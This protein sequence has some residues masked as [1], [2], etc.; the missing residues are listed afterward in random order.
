MIKAMAPQLRTVTEGEEILPGVTVRYTPGHSAGSASYAIEAGGKGVICFGD[1]FHTPLQVTH[2]RWENTF[3]HNHQQSTSL[4]ESLVH[5]LAEPHHRL[6]RALPPAFRPRP[7]RRQPRE[8][9]A[10][11]HLNPT[12]RGQRSA[13]A[14]RRPARRCGGPGRCSE[15][16][17]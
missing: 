4:R 12:R 17:R 7:H 5:E 10:H 2:P 3:D 16:L 8:L 1:A 6:R 11:Q 14:R 15:A 13:P 9:A